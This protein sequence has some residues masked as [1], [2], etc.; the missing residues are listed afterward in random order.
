MERCKN[1]YHWLIIM[2]KVKRRTN[3]MQFA[4]NFTFKRWFFFEKT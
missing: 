1:N 3:W 4:F 2:E